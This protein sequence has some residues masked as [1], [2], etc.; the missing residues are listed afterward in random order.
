MAAGDEAGGRRLVRLALAQN[1]RFD[2]TGA[3]EAR[4]LLGG[5]PKK[6]ASN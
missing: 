4:R 2:W 1:P 6:I 3:A 5:G